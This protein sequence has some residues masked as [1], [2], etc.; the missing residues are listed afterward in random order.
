[1]GFA[2]SVDSVDSNDII[3]YSFDNSTVHGILAPFTVRNGVTF[4]SRA[5]SRIWFRR[6]TAGDAVIV[7]VEAWR[8]E[9]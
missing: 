8:F 2:L 1:M 7:Y 6:Q 3:E 5:Q 4:D 9:C